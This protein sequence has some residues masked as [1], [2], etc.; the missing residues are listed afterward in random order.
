[1]T[2]ALLNSVVNGN[3]ITGLGGAHT[4]FIQMSHKSDN[5]INNILTV[6]I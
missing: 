6:I 5:I 1:M 2:M 4:M 3:D